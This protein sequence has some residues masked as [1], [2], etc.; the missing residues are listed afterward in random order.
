MYKTVLILIITV[1]FSSYVFAQA[2]V[3]GAVNTNAN[4]AANEQFAPNEEADNPDEAGAGM[5]N[6]GI[7]EEKQIVEV[8]EGVGHIPYNRVPFCAA[9][10]LKSRILR[11]SSGAEKVILIGETDDWYRV[12]MYNNEEAYIQ[13]KYVR[14]TKLF[15]DET[16]A[17]NQM[18]KTI[19]IV[20]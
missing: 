10:S 3:N 7:S 14:T 11:Y 9:P 19:S 4:A 6:I 15:M 20:K 16:V 13:K 5:P 8:V 2:A 17:K 18:N 12:I 1:C